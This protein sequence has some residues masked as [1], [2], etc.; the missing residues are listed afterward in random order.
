M[1]NRRRV[2]FQLQR[3]VNLTLQVT[4]AWTEVCNWIKNP[5][6]KPDNY[7]IADISVGN[8]AYALKVLDG[9]ME[10]LFPCHSILIVDPN[11]EPKD[12]SYVIAL[13]N[14]SKVPI[15]RQFIINGADKYIK[16]LSPDTDIYKMRQLETK[17]R[18]LAT[19]VQARWNYR[20]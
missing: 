12:R 18:I 20:V 16:P 2:N 3:W 15:F 9:A 7:I 14:G 8:K 1:F 11:I 5:F 4:L 10:P 19:V 6:T 13:I 17:D